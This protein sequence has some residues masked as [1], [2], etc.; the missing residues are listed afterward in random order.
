MNAALSAPTNEINYEI[1]K[2]R[3]VNFF[4]HTF[5]ILVSLSCLFPLWW[6]FASSL[7]T[8]ET[9]FNDLSLFPKN[10]HWEN[11]FLAWTKADFRLY[12]LN[13]L[14]PSQCNSYKPFYRGLI[15]AIG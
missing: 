11:Y 14:L 13:S 8:Q 10:P 15:F 7:K 4:A 9:V 12:F 5:L 1:I 3:T 2:R 6:A